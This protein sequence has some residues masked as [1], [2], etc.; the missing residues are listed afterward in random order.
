MNSGRRK[1]IF[2]ANWKM[3]LSAAEA[4]Q[5][6]REMLA[7]EL[8]E[9]AQVLIFPPALYL[10]SL[11]ELSSASPIEIGAQN[12]YWERSGAYT[13][14]ISAP[15]I[16]EAGAK[17]VIC[18]HSERRHIFGESS[19]MVTRKAGAA[20][21]EGITT[22]I[23]IGETLEERNAGETLEV[24][25]SDTLSSLAAVGPDKRLIIAYEP[26]WAIGTGLTATPQDAETSIAY[27]REQVRSIWGGLADE[28]RILYGGSV[29]ASNI[30]ELIA[31]P[32]IDGAL[33][34]GASLKPDSFIEIIKN[35]TKL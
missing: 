26:V 18:G 27:I 30:A 15:M 28:I 19:E 33:I 32:N 31:C 34:G 2:A 23:C 20:Q 10:R 25:Q 3:N 4:E 14:E 16:N 22:L 12:I 5:F 6:M 8:P 9:D 21:D 7:E 11:A 35:G 24:L 1:K 13:G 29:N 17:F